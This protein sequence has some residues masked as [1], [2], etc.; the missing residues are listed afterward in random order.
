MKTFR[1]IILSIALFLLSVQLFSQDTA[2]VLAVRKAFESG[3]V[4]EKSANYSVAITKIKSV[5][6]ESSYEIN[7]RLGYLYYESA[8]YRQSEN[9]YKKAI[10]LK[11][12]SI[13][14]KLGL[15]LPLYALAS[16]DTLKMQY[17]AILKLDPANSTV[18]YRMGAIYYYKADYKTALPYFE[19]TAASY[20]FDYDNDIMLAWT[21]LKLGKYTEAKA[22]FNTV[23]LLRPN[24]V[25]AL[26][27][28]KEIMPE[29]R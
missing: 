19:K 25:S 10:A 3:Y 2:K 20:P 16:W 1:Q 4:F 17:E 8:M 13:E 15:A 6:D 29:T 23:L 27:G 14:A 28:L 7:L 22:W 18:N 5:Y 24:D 9:Y 26:T 11:P 12:A 21:Y